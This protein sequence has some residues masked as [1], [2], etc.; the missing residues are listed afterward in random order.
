[1]WAIKEAQVGKVDNVTLILQLEH[2]EETRKV[3]PNAFSVD[4]E[5]Q[6]GGQKGKEVLTMAL[7]VTNRNTDK[8]F[9]FTAALHTYFKVADISATAVSG[10]KGCSFIDKVHQ[11]ALSHETS[12]EL[13]VASEVDR[14]YL[15]VPGVVEIR[16]SKGGHK[17]QLH[18][19]GFPDVVVWNPWIE[20]AKAMADLGDEDYK[21][22][23][24][25]EAGSI[26]TPVQLQPGGT[27]VAKQTI[28]RSN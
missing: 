13:K 27:W 28:S 6:I 14:V 12:E 2:N 25:C 26:G 15:N 20:K 16:D 24:C 18:R 10:L 21:E 3:W 11:G 23:V 4:L 17:T 22:F 5:I 1:L 7:Q 8:P 9:S 19:E